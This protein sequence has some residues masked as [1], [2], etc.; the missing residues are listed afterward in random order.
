MNTQAVRR[1]QVIGNHMAGAVRDEVKGRSAPQNRSFA[2]VDEMKKAVGT[3]VGRV[4]TFADATCDWQWI[5]TE[6]ERAKK[7]SPFG[8]PVAHGFLTLSLAP[9]LNAEA[10]PRLEGVKMGVNYG[11]NK[12]RFI[13]PVHVGAS[14]RTRVTLKEVTDVPGGIQVIIEGTFEV[15]EKGKSEPSKKPVAI[16]EQIARYY[17]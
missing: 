13:A 10:I 14:V 9:F 4:N 6:P 3:E 11:L 7:E 16:V 8:G 1:V 5:H 2:N 15:K 17:V 12:V